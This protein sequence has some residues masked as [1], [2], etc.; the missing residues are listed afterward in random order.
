[1]KYIQN[2]IFQNIIVGTSLPKTYI[3]SFRRALAFLY[4]LSE[5]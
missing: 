2:G 4:K 1:M 5:T 3:I